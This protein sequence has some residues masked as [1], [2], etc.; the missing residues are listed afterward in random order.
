MK[1]K[2]MRKAAAAMLSAVMAVSVLP[3]AGRMDVSAKASFVKLHTAFK[4]LTVG[5]TYKLK[6]KNNALGWKVTNAAS[7]DSNVCKAVNKKTYVKLAAKSEGR[8]TVRVTL[9][10]AKRK[11]ANATKRLSCR[12]NVKPLGS[13]EEP[14]TPAEPQEPETRTDVT[15]GTQAELNEAL[16]N[17]DYTKITL[18]TN[19][20]GIFTIPAGEHANV[21]FTVNAPNADVENHAVFRSITI[22][23]I[24]ENT[25]KEYAKGNLLKILDE[26]ASLVID[27]AAS[28]KEITYA[29]TGVSTA[30]KLD[31]HGTVERIDFQT[32][33]KVTVMVAETASVAGIRCFAQKTE[34]KLDVRGTVGSVSLEADVALDLTGSPKE[35]VAVTVAETAK[36]AQVKSSVK[37]AIIV[38][39]EISILLEKGAEGSSI[40]VTVKEITVSI[41]NKTGAAV[42]LKQPDG[43]VRKI[44]INVTIS[45][46]NGQVVTQGTGSSSGTTYVPSTGSSGSSSSGGSNVPTIDTSKITASLSGSIVVTGT[47]LNPLEDGVII[48]EHPEYGLISY[49]VITQS[50]LKIHVNVPENIIIDQ[51]EDDEDDG[52]GF[53]V[54]DS[55]D[56]SCRW[57]VNWER[58]V[59]SIDGKP[60]D[61]DIQIYFM[62]I[63]KK[64][65]WQSAGSVLT[66]EDWDITSLTKEEY[67]KLQESLLNNQY[68]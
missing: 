30:L 54:Y 53:S 39:A 4:T 34:V 16:A 3:Y 19:E 63:L 8:T 58:H 1:Y 61:Q 37:I 24:K 22:Q 12:V 49:G 67:D 17:Q 29:G 64:E 55:G 68:D 48:S 51:V 41:A 28:V 57:F 60:V 46:K 10:T 65:K 13:M 25:W 62:I 59:K 35:A 66:A 33:V 21:D 40:E 27:A 56:M 43:T 9:K 14:D 31:I 42:E 2:F 50:S 32:S 52:D 18:Q 45:V 15:V 23:D 7:K 5:Q 44:A 11:G 38:K 36:G 47:A 26:K 20:A 6:L